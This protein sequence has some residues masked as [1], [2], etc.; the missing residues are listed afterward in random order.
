MRAGGKPTGERMRTTRERSVIHVRTSLAAAAGG[1]T[2]AL[3]ALAAVQ[4]AHS[5]AQAVVLGAASLSL[6]LTAL[7]AGMWLATGREDRG[8]SGGLLVVFVLAAAAGLMFAG[9]HAHG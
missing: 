1:G 2:G 8:D 3:G 7:A 5:A 6:A 4:S 9:G